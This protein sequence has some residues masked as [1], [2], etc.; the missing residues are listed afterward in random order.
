MGN[1]RKSSAGGQ[2]KLQTDS[3]KSENTAGSEKSKNIPD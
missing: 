1:G 2:R 3:E